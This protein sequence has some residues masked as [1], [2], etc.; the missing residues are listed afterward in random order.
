MLKVLDLSDN[1]RFPFWLDHLPNLEV[2]ILWSN[3]FNGSMEVHQTYFKFPNM[4]L[5]SNFRKIAGYLNPIRIKIPSN[6]SKI[7]S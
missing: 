4:R 5:V 2:L 1:D 7:A 6:F 3:K